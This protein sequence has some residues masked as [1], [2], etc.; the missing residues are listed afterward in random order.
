MAG[1]LADRRLP[2]PEPPD[3]QPPCGMAG[4]IDAPGFLLAPGGGRAFDRL[5]SL[6]GAEAEPARSASPG[7]DDDALLVRRGDGAVAAIS[8]SGR[9]PLDVAKG[10]LDVVRSRGALSAGDLEELPSAANPTLARS[11]GLR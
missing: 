5:R 2:L 3:S 9:R 6:S 4:A 8:L 11:N 1:G 10:P 7:P